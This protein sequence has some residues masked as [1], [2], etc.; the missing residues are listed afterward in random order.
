MNANF[1]TVTDGLIEFEVDGQF[2]I[3]LTRGYDLKLEVEYP[4][5][6]LSRVATKS[7]LTFD[8]SGSQKTAKW[9]ASFKYDELDKSI[10]LEGRLTNKDFSFLIKSNIPTIE[11]VKGKIAWTDETN[12]TKVTFLFAAKGAKQVQVKPCSRLNILK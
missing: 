4:L 10:S 8:V 3:D 5:V 2:T 6:F 9:D 11:E 1:Q 7:S 12:K